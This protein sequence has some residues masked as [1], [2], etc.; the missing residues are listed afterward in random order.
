MKARADEVA[1][2][3]AQDSGNTFRQ[4][5]GATKPAVSSLRYYAGVDCKLKWQ[6]IPGEPGMLHMIHEPYG[7][8]V[9]IVPFNHPKRFTIS[10]TA[11]PLA[12]GNALIVKA[13]ETGPLPG[14][15][16]GKIARPVLQPGV[17]TIVTGSG[18]Q[19]GERWCVIGRSSASPPAVPKAPEGRSRGQQPNPA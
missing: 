12:A 8:V 11:T 19:I 13:P 4:V 3:G 1:Q 9:R 16:I 10:R 15:L 6:T 14:F 2:F 5:Q 18:A 7:V 17:F